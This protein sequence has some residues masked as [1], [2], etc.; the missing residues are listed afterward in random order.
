MG[1][2]M[3]ISWVLNKLGS[4]IAGKLTPKGLVRGRQRSG[5]SRFP[6][7]RSP[8]VWSCRA[9]SVMG[10]P[11]WGDGAPLGDLIGRARLD[12]ARSLAHATASQDPGSSA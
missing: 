11:A 5:P 6:R 9:S 3:L 10:E 7:S 8:V 12:S 1:F 2:D 4:K